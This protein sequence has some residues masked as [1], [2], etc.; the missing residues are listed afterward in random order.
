MKK[1]STNADSARLTVRQLAHEEIR[2]QIYLRLGVNAA[3]EFYTAGIVESR[4]QRRRLLL[5][6][7]GAS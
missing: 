3:V 7:A 5:C 2:A 1:R 6:V 4:S